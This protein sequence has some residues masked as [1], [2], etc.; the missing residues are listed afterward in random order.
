MGGRVRVW[1]ETDEGLKLACSRSQTLFGN[2]LARETL[3][4]C[5]H[6]KQSWKARPRPFGLGYGQ[7]NVI[8]KQSLEHSQPA[9]NSHDSIADDTDKI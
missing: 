7:D 1:H 6:E 9:M 3:F 2:A 4:R 5:R 8:P